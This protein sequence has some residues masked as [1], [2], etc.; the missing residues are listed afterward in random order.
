MFTSKW[1]ERQKYVP[2]LPDPPKSKPAAT[3]RPAPGM[4]PGSSIQYHP[5]LIGRFKDQH[6]ELQK[7]FHAIK[8][9]VQNSDFVDV[10]KSLQA[11][12]QALMAHLLEENIKLY[13]Y[14]SRCVAGNADSRELMLNLKS[15]MERV[16]TA[17]MRIINKH[18]DTDAT[19]T[20]PDR[21]TLLDDLDEVGAMLFNRIQ[22]EETSLYELYVPPEDFR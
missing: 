2:L 5:D 1:F 17:M 20:S 8:S 9:Q 21:Q 10:R 15:E 18:T 4:A 19:A 14:L 13:T 6:A 22:R 16:G 12:K 7:T 3:L 11:F